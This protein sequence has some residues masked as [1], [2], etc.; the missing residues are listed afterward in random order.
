MGWLPAVF[1]KVDGEVMGSF[2]SGWNQFLDQYCLFSFVVVFATICE[3]CHFSGV[4]YIMK[5]I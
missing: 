2:S 5:L 4:Q 3:S 1:F